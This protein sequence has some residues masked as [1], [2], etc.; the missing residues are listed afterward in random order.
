MQNQHL[1]KVFFGSNNIEFHWATIQSKLTKRVMFSIRS[2]GNTKQLLKY[3][4]TYRNKHYARFKFSMK[5]ICMRLITR[6]KGNRI[7][8]EINYQILSVQ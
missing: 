3:L 7:N 2:P 4:D 5:D 1:V 6:L 8:D